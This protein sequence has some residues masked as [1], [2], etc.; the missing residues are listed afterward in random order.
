MNVTS[1]LSSGYLQPSGRPVSSDLNAARMQ[2]A[3]LALR[4][5]QV[6]SEERALKST[7]QDVFTTWHYTVGP[8]GRRYITGAEVVVRGS[9][10][11]MDRLP[12]GVKRQELKPRPT[13]AS[14]TEPT[15]ESSP[16]SEKNEK[17][18]NG[19]DDNSDAARKLKQIEQDVIAHEAAHQAA[20]GRF[21][22]PV[23]YTYTQGPDGKRYITGGEVPIHVPASDDP[24]QTLR[25]M[26]QVRRAALAPG[27]PSGQD[28]SVAA[29]AAMVA[30]QARQEIASS[31]EPRTNKGRSSFKAGVASIQADIRSGQIRSGES[32]P[33]IHPLEPD[34]PKTAYERTASQ[35]GLWTP[36]RGFEPGTSRNRP[37][38]SIDIAA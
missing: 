17:K 20:G 36:V 9:E 38:D 8:D 10:E 34:D 35:Y 14:E 11:E 15:A 37:N 4:E 7:S 18:A 25:D 5:Q 33:D 23:S 29:Q 1:M 19:A 22:G 16:K 28:L 6:L 21:A 13:Q 27:D 32:V 26:E 3:S 31:D 24:E 30:A 12:G 2:S